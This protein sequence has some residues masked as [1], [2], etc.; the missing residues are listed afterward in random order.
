MLKDKYGNLIPSRSNIIKS[1]VVNGSL[2]LDEF[3]N[4][5]L[6]ALINKTDKVVSPL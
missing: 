1:L 5:S 3:D 2:R 6:Y 4:S